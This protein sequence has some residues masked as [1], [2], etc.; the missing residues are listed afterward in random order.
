MEATGRLGAD[1][2][3]RLSSGSRACPTRSSG[4]EETAQDLKTVAFSSLSM[5]RQGCGCGVLQETRR[6]GHCDGVRSSGCALTSRAT[7]VHRAAASAG[8]G[9]K[10]QA[11]EQNTEHQQH[12]HSLFASI[13]TEIHHG[14]E[15]SSQR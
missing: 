6:P 4:F 9:E 2:E 10:H 3:V 14:Y 12:R 11:K 1:E 7:G 15:Q 13:R 5:N 8:H